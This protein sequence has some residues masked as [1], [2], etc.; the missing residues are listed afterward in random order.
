MKHEIQGLRL[1]IYPVCIIEV[2]LF[3]AQFKYVCGY[4][5]PGN[6]KY[7]VSLFRMTLPG[8]LECTRC[9]LGLNAC[10][11]SGLSF[12]SGVDI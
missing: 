6:S 12:A 8:S 10:L 7:T 3:S 2:R 9:Y 5:G 4:S 1:F 11:L